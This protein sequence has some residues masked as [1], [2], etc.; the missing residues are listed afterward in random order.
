[1]I[2]SLVSNKE[3]FEPLRPL[4]PHETSKRR[5]IAPGQAKADRTEPPKGCC[6]DGRQVSG[7]DPLGVPGDY[8]GIG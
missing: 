7:K 2:E 6:C 5:D 4:G 8:F 3:S 1:M